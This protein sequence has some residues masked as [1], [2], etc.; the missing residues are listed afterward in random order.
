LH[1]TKYLAFNYQ[2]V[3]SYYQYQGFGTA[4]SGSRHFAE[5]RARFFYEKENKNSIK[6]RHICLFKPQQRT[7]R[8]TPRNRESLNMKFLNFSLFFGTILACLDKDPL[9]HIP[10]PKH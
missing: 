7:F 1:L 4:E 8:T 3:G 6:N 10:N 5:S 2:Q 9:I